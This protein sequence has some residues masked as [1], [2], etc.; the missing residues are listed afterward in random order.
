MVVPREGKPSF[1]V[2]LV[3]VKGDAADPVVAPPLVLRHA[4]GQRSAEH[5]AIREW[6]GIP[7]RG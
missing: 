7:C 1:L 5:V 4:E 3:A 6:T 2:L